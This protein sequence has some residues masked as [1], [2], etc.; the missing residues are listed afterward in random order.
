MLA[1]RK[2]TCRTRNVASIFKSFTTQNPNLRPPTI[3]SCGRYDNLI[4]AAGREREFAAVRY[5]LNKRVRDGCFNTANTFNFIST[6]LSVLDELSNHL[7][8]LSGFTRKSA[9]DSLVAQLSKMHRIPEAIR[10]AEMMVTNDFG[11]T[12]STFHPIVNA[13]TRKKEMAK[14]WRVMEAMRACKIQ[15]DVTAFNHILT[16]FCFTGDLKSAADVLESME[17]EG[18]AADARTYDALVLGACKAGRL[19]VALSVLRRMMDDKLPALYCTYAH[20]IKGMVRSGYDAQAVEFVRSFAGKDL[21]LDTENF[22]ILATHLINMNKI[23]EAKNV[24]KE[25]EK[26]GL[27]MSDQ[28]KDFCELN[29]FRYKE[30][31]NFN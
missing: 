1:L 15:P 31:I 27:I 19:D 5:L 23:E 18:M 6:D 12:A 28:L 20:V 16:A 30:S 21:K 3:P 7:A 9:Y 2:F 13:L 26:R 11:A 4:N 10:V 14:A 17:E 8:A 22:G 25:M 24:A 29:H